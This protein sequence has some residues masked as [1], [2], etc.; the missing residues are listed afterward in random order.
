MAAANAVGDKLPIFIIG[1]SKVFC[2][3]SELTLPFPRQGKSWINRNL[4]EEWLREL[5]SKF[6]AER[7][8]IALLVD[9]CPAHPHVDNLKAID[10]IFL[11]TNNTASTQPMDQGVI[12]SLKAKYRVFVVQKY[13]RALD[14]KMPLPKI[15]IISAMN[16]LVTAWSMVTKTTVINFFTKAGMSA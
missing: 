13:I 9:N 5:D 11:P 1:K 7:R 6:L 14:R 3:D 10:L 2:W 4:F 8:K 16:M 15:N 12:R